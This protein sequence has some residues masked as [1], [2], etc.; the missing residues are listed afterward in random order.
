MIDLNHSNRQRL[1]KLSQTSPLVREAASR[2]L[3]DSPF[4]REL[5]A[6]GVGVTVDW[7][8]VGPRSMRKINRQQR[9]IDSETDILSFPARQMIR[10][11]PAAPIEN[12]EYLETGG[13]R[14]TILLGDLVISPSR[15][16]DQA[17]E[18]G[19]GFEREFTFLVIHG[20]LHLLGYRH[21]TEEE[22][23][24]MNAL[25]DR[26]MQSLIE[27]PCGFVAITGRP[28]V[29]KSTLLNQLSN[30]TLAITTDKPQTTRQAVRSVLTS[31]DYQVALLDT[32]GLHQP[33]NALGKAMMKATS[34]AVAQADVLAVMIDASWSPFAGSLERRVIEQA[35]AAGKAVVLV[36]NKVDRAPK[37]N[38]L[39]LIKV[40][41]DLYKL[42]AYVPVSALGNDGIER[43]LHELVRLLPVRRRLFDP[44]D[45]TNQTE[46]MLAAELIRREILLQTKEEVPYGTTVLIDRFEEEGEGEREVF[47][48][49]LIYCAKKTHKQII[50]GKGGERIKAIGLAS[51]RA[52]ETMLDARVHL[53]LFVKVKL[54]WQD[55][56]S[57]LMDA[58]LMERE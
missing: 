4:V 45:E 29:G 7:T 53:S 2:V 52:I 28:N 44:E 37:E 51:R 48:D 3:Y 5:M 15:V 10:G 21:D 38:I 41:D 57:D 17:E 32:P 33:K 6:E 35:Q 56:P 34:S 23:K 20:L 31:A 36:I 55:R 18:L 26:F 13:G 42:D 22:E 58:G 40:Y 47:I 11:Q 50:V 14:R 24:E 25:Q 1:F 46:K 19:H 12:W 49:A 16:A 27:I 43:L 54:G 8:L 30:R 9:G 39:P